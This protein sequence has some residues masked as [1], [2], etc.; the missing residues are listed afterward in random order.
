MK[1]VDVLLLTRDKGTAAAAQSVLGS[2]A[3]GASTS[4]CEDIVELRT[5][6]SRPAGNRQFDVVVV[7]IDADPEHVLYELGKMVVSNPQT[8][9]VVLSREFDEKLV[10]QA[11]QVGARHFLRKSSIE[12]EL[13]SVIEHLIVQ[14]AKP[15]THMGDVISVLSCSGGSGATTV[16]VNLA[17]ELQ[18]ESLKSVLLV[19]LDPHYGSVASYLGLKGNY[20]ISHLLNREG[21]LDKH[22]IESTML[23]YTPGLDVLLSPAVAQADKGQPMNYGNLLKALGACR[24]SHRY[25]IL[26]A[27]RLPAQS[28]TDLASVSRVAVVVF[29]LTVR[30]VA[31]AGSLI[32][33]LIDGGMTREQIVPLANRVKRRGPLLR[34]ADSERAIGS[35]S[36][37]RIRSDWVKAIKS[38]N[39]GQPL[40]D[41]ARRSR[42]RRDFRKLAARIQ[43][44][45]ANGDSQG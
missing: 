15:P 2:G 12:S 6:L 43:H 10:L 26:D 30:D 35:G 1:K 23:T 13:D 5:Q 21:P 17:T 25:V 36:L 29:Q 11:M 22:L 3:T 14:E 4:L 44:L 32:R 34:L 41:M 16:A 39:R 20:G 28:V 9:F 38:I 27:P 24:E 31:F 45:T 18:I 19:D 42:L 33:S 40:A 37:M 7:D 8:R